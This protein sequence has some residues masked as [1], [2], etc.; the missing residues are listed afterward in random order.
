MT[1]RS[2]VRP[3]VAWLVLAAGGLLAAACGGVR[4]EALDPES[5]DFFDTVRLVMTDI[6][7]TI[8]RHL[9]DAA[10]RREFIADFWAKRDPDPETEGNEFKEEFDRRVEYANTHFREGR[11]GINTDRGR[12]YLYLG[13]PEHT[14]S[15]PMI[16]GG[17][18]SVLWWIYYSY[19]LGVEF[20]DSRGTGEY[21]INEI[22][23]NLFDAI[24]RAKLGAGVQ[25]SGAHLNFVN[26]DVRYDKDRR[27][28]VVAVPTKKLSFKEEGSLL[29]AD[30]EFTFYLYRQGAAKEKFVE[31]RTFS[32]LAAE[33]EKRKEI[34][35][36]FP[37]ELAPGRVF[38]DVTV[39][40]KQDNGRVRKIV[41]VKA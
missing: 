2:A 36:A 24:E 34:T 22:D 41:E 38:V 10:A 40:G 25:R 13:P 20:V 11:R 3:P 27:E 7:R 29:S 37:R 21:A 14:E 17:L 23:G 9:P 1:R 28:L 5:R 32:A 26:F 12:I 15:F 33:L 31:T 19:P 8:F 4:V 39:N 35:F 18:T 16:D 30:F 6:E